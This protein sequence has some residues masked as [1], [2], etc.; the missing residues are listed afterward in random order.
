MRVTLVDSEDSESAVATLQASCTAVNPAPMTD[1][2]LPSLRMTEVKGSP[3]VSGS[4]EDK[5]E[6][7]DRRV[8]SSQTWVHLTAPLYKVKIATRGLKVRT[9]TG[10]PTCHQVLMHYL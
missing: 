5:L 8:S 10:T 4:V 6:D 1:T 9:Q 2:D 3:D 7:I